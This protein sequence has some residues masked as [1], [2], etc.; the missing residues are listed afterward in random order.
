[1]EK[2]INYSRVTDRYLD[3]E[4]NG[5]EQR[6]YEDELLSNPDLAKDLELH[7]EVNQAIQET[8]IIR[9]RNQLDKIHASIEPE[10]QPSIA[11]KVLHNKYARI[12][13][14]TVVVLVAIGLFLNNMLSKPVDSTEL[15]QCYYQ[16][17]VLSVT[18]R[19]DAAMDNLFHDA[20][21]HFNNGRFTDA[22]TLFEKVIAMDRSNMKAHLATGISNIEINQPKEAEE[23]F[24]TVI[25]HEDNL[26][27]DQADWFLALCY[28]K[29][30]DLDN[31]RLQFDRI[32][33]NDHSFKQDEARRILKK[34]NR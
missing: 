7:R 28:L 2:R 25:L 5:Q 26:Y 33:S 3:G 4:L 19:S 32:A 24:E 30:N 6:W 23:S 13:A 16:A 8:D 22:L 34:L 29:T 15:F 11:R 12:A 21:I 18:V 10:Y 9:F 1:M 17:P 20:V 31:A 14:A 27:V